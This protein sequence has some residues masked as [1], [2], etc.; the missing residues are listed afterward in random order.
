MSKE[1]EIAKQVITEG[2]EFIRQCAWLFAFTAIPAIFVCAIVW[3]IVI[4][5][6]G[7]IQ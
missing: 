2:F 6:N 3:G 7:G 4:L 1:M 5:I